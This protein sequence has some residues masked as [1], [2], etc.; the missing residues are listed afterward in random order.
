MTAIKLF[1]TERGHIV[2]VARLT[3]FVITGRLIAIGRYA[4]IGESAGG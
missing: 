4:L 2:I 3:M 1:A